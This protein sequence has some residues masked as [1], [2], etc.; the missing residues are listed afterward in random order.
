MASPFPQGKETQETTKQCLAQQTPSSACVAV[1]FSLWSVC[2]EARHVRRLVNSPL[3]LPDGALQSGESLLSL[4][5]SGP[6][7]TTQTGTVVGSSDFL[8]EEV[9]VENGMEK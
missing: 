6:P 4:A 9:S 1:A 3:L 7:P 5:L 8:F 2:P